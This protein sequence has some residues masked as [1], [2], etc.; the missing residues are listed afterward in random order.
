MH[1]LELMPHLVELSDHEA[2]RW[3][4]A[5]VAEAQALR[6]HDGRLYPTRND[7]ALVET[8]VALHQAWARWADDAE[9]LLKRVPANPQNNRVPDIDELRLAIGY[10]RGLTQLSPEEFQ[11]RQERVNSGEAKTF[12]PAEAR[13]E[14]G[15]VP[16]KSVSFPDFS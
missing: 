10:A 11:H 7:L 6:Q 5:A 14:L 3:I 9:S 12:S 16:L 4:A 13:R 2:Q 8:A 1:T 15:I